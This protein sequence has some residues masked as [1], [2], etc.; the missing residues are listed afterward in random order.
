MSHRR[1]R[2]PVDAHVHF[3]SLERVPS[4]LDAA[5]HNFHGAGARQ[6]G[7]LGALLLTEAA[8]EA[9]F[10][11]LKGSV[12]EVGGWRFTQAPCEEQ[13]LI[14]RREKEAIAIICGRQVRAADGLEV[15]ALGTCE[16]F[17]EGLPFS[18]AVETVRQSGALAAIPW[19]FGKWTGARAQRVRAMLASTDPADLFLGDNGGRVE[20]MGAPSIIE[21]AERRGFRVLPGTDPFPFSTDQRRVGGFGLLADVQPTE[22]APWGTLRA[23]LAGL[24]A[25]P[26][27]YGRAI[28]PVRFALN[29]LG[30][31][32]YNRFLKG[33][34]A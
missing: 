5:A 10:E 9:V 3:H 31:Q 16:Q 19:G 1:Y 24:D 34:K 14:A 29:Q 33:R 20:S 26:E 25:S 11:A 27:R 32:V 7:L 4:T 13:S 18:Q 28:G 30:I 6:E 23:W 8:G 17:P 12:P 15:L 22:E 21:D 2:W